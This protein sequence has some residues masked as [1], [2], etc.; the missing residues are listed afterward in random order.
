MVCIRHFHTISQLPAVKASLNPA[1]IKVYA[2][3]GFGFD[4]ASKGEIESVLSIGVN[5]ADIVYAN[6]FKAPEYIT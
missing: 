3:L 1:M 2:S 5:P 4:C 6:P